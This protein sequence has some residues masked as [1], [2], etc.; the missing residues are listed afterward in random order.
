MFPF[1]GRPFMRAEFSLIGRNSKSIGPESNDSPKS[2]PCFNRCDRRMSAL[3][4]DKLIVTECSRAPPRLESHVVRKSCGEAQIT[5]EHTLPPHYWIS[6]TFMLQGA[7]VSVSGMVW[8]PIVVVVGFAHT[9]VTLS[10]WS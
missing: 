10:V 2:S 7:R 5:T 3:L 6:T 4:T 8:E 9:G 1:K